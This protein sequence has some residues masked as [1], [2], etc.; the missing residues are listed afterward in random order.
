MNTEGS[1]RNGTRSPRALTGIVLLALLVAA[2]IGLPG[3]ATAV[4]GPSDLALTKSDSPD[5]VTVGSNLTYTVSVR[6]PGPNDAT[7]VVVTDTLPSQVDFVSATASSGTCNR[8]GNTVTCN[9][10]QVDSGVTATA[11][12]V[13]TPR[14][15]GTI[16]NSASVATTV[17]DSNTANNQDT[18]STVVNK[19]TTPTKGKKKGKKKGRASCAT[20]TITGTLGDDTLTGT[21]KGDVILALDGNDTVFAGDGKDLICAGGGFDLVS[22]GPKSDTVIGGTARDRLFGNTGGDVLKGKA[23]RDRLR[24]NKDDDFLN[25]GRGRDGCRGGAGR[26]T[27]RRCP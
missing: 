21:S 18:E 8:S 16:S 13:V 14:K 12:I 19:A 11:T 26:D 23:G 1:A 20:P 15:T 17:A 4:V 7:A 24:G 2:L 6:N 27:L 22:G 3:N 10:G 25:G 5:P 9:L